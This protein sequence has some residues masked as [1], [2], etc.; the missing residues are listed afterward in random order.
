M[1]G[2]MKREENVAVALKYI[3][4]F[5][6]K[7]NFKGCI[8]GGFACYLYGVNRPVDEIHIDIELDKDDKKFKS[9]IEDVKEFT[10][11]SFQYYKDKNYDHYVMEITVND[12]ILSICT[13]KNLKMFNKHGKSDLFYK[14]G[15]PKSDIVLFRGLQLPLLSKEKVIEMKDAL[16]VKKEIDIK[17]ISEMRKILNFAQQRD[18]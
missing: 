1:D 9:F 3:I 18:C 5:L 12:F 4:P 16:A 13:T 10:T 11:Y 8:S 15:I 14:K 6:K 7:Y 17:D 2:K